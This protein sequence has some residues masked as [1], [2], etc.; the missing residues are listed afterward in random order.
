MA[1]LAVPRGHIVDDRVAKD[2]I[3]GLSAENVAAA[4]ADHQRQLDLV[5]DLLGHRAVKADRRARADDVL[6]GFEMTAG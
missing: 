5:V 3:I 6:A 2:V 4:S 1:L